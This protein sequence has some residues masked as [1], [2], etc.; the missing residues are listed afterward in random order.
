MG[1]VRAQRSAV[2]TTSSGV[3]VGIREGQAFDA[4]D[5]VVREFPWVFDPPVEQAT[6]A[7]GERRSTKR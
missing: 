1:Q 4:D 3:V 6:A 7:P 2:I 5:S